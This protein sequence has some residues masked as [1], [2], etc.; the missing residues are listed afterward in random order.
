MSK[1]VG[2]LERLSCALQF[3]YD[4]GQM[5]AVAGF[6]SLTSTQPWSVSYNHLMA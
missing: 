1:N 5:G 3:N 4:F 2:L 6:K